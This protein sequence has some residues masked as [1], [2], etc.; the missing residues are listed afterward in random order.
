MEPLDWDV[1]VPVIEAPR[2]GVNP[3]GDVVELDDFRLV[4]QSPKDGYWAVSLATGREES[5]DPFGRV[6]VTYSTKMLV[7]RLVAAA[8][9]PGRTAER[10]WVNH[11]DG[12]KSYNYFENLEWVTPSENITHAIEYGLR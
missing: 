6:H 10:R 11:I 7:H 2:F 4:P 3:Y 1:W 9:V 8:F 5:T 12:D